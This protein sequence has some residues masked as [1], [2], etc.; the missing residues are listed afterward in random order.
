MA[1]ARNIKPAFFLNDELAELEPFAR[2]LFIGLWCLAD[3]DGYLEDKPKKIKASLFPYDD[4]DVDDLLNKLNGKF[5]KRYK[6]NDGKYIFI[7]NFKKHQNPHYS[8]KTSEIPRIEKSGVN[9]ECSQN[10]L[11]NSESNPADSLKLIPDSLKLI[12][13]SLKQNLDNVNRNREKN[14]LC[15]PSD[16]DQ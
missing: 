11:E 9:Q 13:D 12:P 14:T 5:I 10:I 3:R 7:F 16:H 1:R 2:L 4:I 15:R 6:V 8:E